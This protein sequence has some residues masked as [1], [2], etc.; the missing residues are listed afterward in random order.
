MFGKLTIFKNSKMYIV[1]VARR[2]PVLCV[3]INEQH[4]DASEVSGVT[5]YSL[6]QLTYICYFFPLLLGR[7]ESNSDNKRLVEFGK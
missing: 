7:K 2:F 5:N 4:E 3:S 6:H 1:F